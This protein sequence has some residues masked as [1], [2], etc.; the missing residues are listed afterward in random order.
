MSE[1]P[2]VLTGRMIE[3]SRLATIGE[4]MSGVAHELNQPLTAIANFAQACVRLLAAPQ[5]DVAEVNDALHEI[6]AQALRA[7]EVIRRIREL[8]RRPAGERATADPARIVEDLREL[9][10]AESRGAGTKVRWSCAAGLPPVHVERIQIQHALLNFVSNAMDA[11][12]LLPPAKRDVEIGVRRAVDGAGIEFFVGDNGP[13]IAADA[14]ARLGEPF[15]TT[16][17]TGTGLGLA[18]AN[19]IART[20][21]GSIRYEANQPRGARFILRIP[22]TSAAES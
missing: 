20:H 10:L 1:D 9:I 7:G 19:T 6:T 14:Q 21:E 12:A 15:F 22:A 16:K 2:A 13:G 8:A 3:V 17:A 5:A 18:I 11:V 4:M